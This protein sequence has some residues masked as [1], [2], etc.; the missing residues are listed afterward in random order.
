MPLYNDYTL[1]QP[2]W[3]K[4]TPGYDHYDALS[5]ALVCDLAYQTTGHDHP[6]ATDKQAI[7]RQLQQWHFDTVDHFDVSNGYDV[8][9]QGFVTSNRER[10]LICFRGTD[11]T[12]DWRANI[13]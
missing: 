5:L 4:V 8:D 9:T 13:Q 1:F 7:E 10:I 11:S 2:N 3:A 6:A 12:E